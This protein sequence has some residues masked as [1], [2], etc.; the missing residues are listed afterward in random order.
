ML[1]FALFNLEGTDKDV[2]KQEEVMRH[3]IK[4]QR[5]GFDLERRRSGMSE[6]WKQ[7]DRSEGHGVCVDEIWANSSAG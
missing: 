4:A 2:P 3:Q 7:R 6:L 1:G 5:I